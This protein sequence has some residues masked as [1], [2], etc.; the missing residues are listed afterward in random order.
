[1]YLGVIDLSKQI[2]LSSRAF[3]LPKLA[4]D[5]HY[6]KGMSKPQML[7]MLLETKEFLQVKILICVVFSFNYT[8]IT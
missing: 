8:I 5:L 1:M 3:S 6:M 2:E 4:L 7:R